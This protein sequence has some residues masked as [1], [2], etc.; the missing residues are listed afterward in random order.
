MTGII[1]EGHATYENWAWEPG[2]VFDVECTQG[3]VFLSLNF[4]SACT[5]YFER[6]C[7]VSPATSN[8]VSSFSSLVVLGKYPRALGG[9]T[10]GRMMK[11]TTVSRFFYGHPY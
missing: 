11:L 7:Y 8:V 10:K 1:L 9:H 2:W 3:S 6:G 4:L 5:R